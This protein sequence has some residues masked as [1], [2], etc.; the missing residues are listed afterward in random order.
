MRRWFRDSDK[1]E[2]FVTGVGKKW[3]A[4]I[5][6]SDGKEPDGYEFVRIRDIKKVR[7]NSDPE[8]IA[9]RVLRARGQW[10]LTA[11]AFDLN[12]TAAVLAD[13]ADAGPLLSLHVERYRPDALWVGGLRSVADGEVV[14][15]GLTPDAEWEAEPSSSTS[16][17]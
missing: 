3:V 6:L 15:D 11:P 4:I 1:V 5:P 10:P 8:F 14:L 9:V 12:T 13:A 7:V 16:A 2:G 17:I